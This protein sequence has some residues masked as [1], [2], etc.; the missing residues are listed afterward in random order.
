MSVLKPKGVIATPK[1][2]AVKLYSKVVLG[3][4]GAVSSQTAEGS[5]GFVFS[6]P[7]G[8]GIYRITTTDLW[9]AHLFTA[10]LLYNAGT[11]KGLAL[12]LKVKYGASTSKVMDY[13]LVDDAGSAAD[14]TSGDEL[15]LEVTMSNTGVGR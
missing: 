15:W 14:G 5:S 9:D 4:S 11:A 8:T 10:F 13:H 7:S 1:L 12:E 3:S 6:K 2:G